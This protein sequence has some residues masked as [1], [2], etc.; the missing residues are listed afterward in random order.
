[1]D[2]NQMIAQMRNQMKS[3]EATMLRTMTE[4]GTDIANE[5]QK[6]V[7]VD[8]GALK[9]SIHSNTTKQGNKIVTTVSCDAT[10]EDG[11]QYWE[12]VEYGTGLYNQKGNGRQTPWTYADGNGQFH[13]TSGQQAQPFVR[14]AVANVVPKLRS[15]FE[16][17]VNVK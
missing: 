10:N 5:M 14:P 7:P 13:T 4:A 15:K 6:R 11:T 9:Q 8:T 16:T 17:E 2:T 3:I 1:M 12:F